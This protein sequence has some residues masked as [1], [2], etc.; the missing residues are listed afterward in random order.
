MEKDIYSTYTFAM[1]DEKT[2]L[3]RLKAPDAAAIDA[4]C[5]SYSKK[6]YP[7]TFNLLKNSPESI[8][9]TE[10]KDIVSVPAG[11]ARGINHTGVVRENPSFRSAGTSTGSQ[12]PL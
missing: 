10:N 11:Q 8:P 1:P 9:E 4:I 5:H 3:N 2:I 12:N 6:L 7:F